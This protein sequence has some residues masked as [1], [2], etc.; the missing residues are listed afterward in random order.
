[1]RIIHLSCW[2]Q[3]WRYRFNQIK[4]RHDL[5]T[6]A[7]SLATTL[8]I[9]IKLNG[10]PPGGPKTFVFFTIARIFALTAM[11]VQ[12]PK[13]FLRKR[14]GI[15][16]LSQCVTLAMYYVSVMQSPFYTT[17]VC[18]L[19]M[20][21]KILSRI[22]FFMFIPLL[23]VQVRKDIL[24]HFNL[25]LFLSSYLSSSIISALPCS[26]P[27]AQSRTSPPSDFSCWGC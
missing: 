5:I 10:I 20:P 18:P 11:V 2:F 6:Q 14:S 25:F 22:G 9:T 13:W 12:A 19:A 21:R 15:L 24:N 16:L 26:L 7:L 23:M 8:L 17:L 1:M 3:V 27:L 4:R